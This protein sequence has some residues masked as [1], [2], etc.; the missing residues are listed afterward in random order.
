M[1]W[2]L[3]PLCSHL[4]VQGRSVPQEP[5][6]LC[7]SLKRLRHLLVC[8]WGADSAQFCAGPQVDGHTRSLQ[9]PSGDSLGRGQTRAQARS[10][11]VGRWGMRAPAGVCEE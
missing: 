5:R 4:S 6:S 8:P 9:D 7:I 3:Q 1:I 10:V 2:A 11:R